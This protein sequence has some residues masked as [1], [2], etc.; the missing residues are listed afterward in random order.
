VSE[1]LLVP[2]NVRVGESVAS[3]IDSVTARPPVNPLALT[4]SAAAEMDS[5]IPLT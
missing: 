1:R 5:V 2:T 4:L 3:E